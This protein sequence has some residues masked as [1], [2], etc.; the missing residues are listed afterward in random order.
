MTIIDE[1]ISEKER[2]DWGV[3]LAEC[4]SSSNI[5]PCKDFEGFVDEVMQILRLACQGVS[6]PFNK[7]TIHEIAKYFEWRDTFGSIPIERRLYF[8]NKEH[9]NSFKRT[10]GFIGNSERDFYFADKRDFQT[11]FYG[12]RLWNEVAADILKRDE[13]RCKL[14]FKGCLKH[15][16]TV[17]H[18]RSAY[19]NPS[20][21]L[22]QLNLISSCSRCH[23]TTREQ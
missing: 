5:D 8:L 4:G 13:F 17:H 2:H 6:L 9:L 12:W 7:N 20:I 19:E 11:R 18:I 22:S 10:G 21:C 1:E 14:R 3:I 16:N 15:A 23:N